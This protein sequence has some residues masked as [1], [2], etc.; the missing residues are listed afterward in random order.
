M[1]QELDQDSIE[2]L[3]NY[4]IQKAKETLI[5]AEFLIHNNFYNTAINRLYYAA[6]YAVNALLIKNRIS[7]QTHAGIK[8]MFGLHF[9]A[10][11]KLPSNTGRLYNQLF[12]YRISG[13]YD[14]FVTYDRETVEDI[15]PKTVDFIKTISDFLHS[16][17]KIQENRK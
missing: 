16:S 5:E 9:I 2:A 12:N 8:Q 3:A 10:S 1:K 7:A 17:G 14:D 4:R 13:D 15:Y 6:Y 11:G